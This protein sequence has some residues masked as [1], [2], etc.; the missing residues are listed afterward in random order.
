MQLE[1]LLRERA[2]RIDYNAANFSFRALRETAYRIADLHEANAESTFGFLLR[3]SIQEYANDVYNDLPVMY[4][5][6][7]TEVQSRRRS[8]VYGGLYRPSLPLPVDA[9]EAFQDST[10]KGFEREIVNRK[11]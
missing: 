10:F 4:P 7:V 11:Y 5:N 1:R 6:F 9:G 3:S 8:E 2:A